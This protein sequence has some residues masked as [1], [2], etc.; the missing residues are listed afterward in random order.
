[1]VVA[2]VEEETLDKL[3]KVTMALQTL[4]VAVAE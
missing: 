2:Q 1:V 3:L 4:V